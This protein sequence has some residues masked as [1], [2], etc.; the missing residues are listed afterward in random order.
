MQPDKRAVQ[1]DKFSYLVRLS[2]CPAVRLNR[3]L[4]CQQVRPNRLDQRS[5]ALICQPVPNTHD[6]GKISVFDVGCGQGVGN[7]LCTLTQPLES[8]DV[9]R[10]EL[11]I[12]EPMPFR[13]SRSLRHASFVGWVRSPVTNWTTS[14][15]RSPCVSARLD[16]RSYTVRISESPFSLLR[17]WTISCSDRPI[18]LTESSA[19]G[20]FP[21]SS[22]PV[23]A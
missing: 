8:W 4:S 19:P 12:Q 18:S 7:G 6:E 20:R 17:R 16:R 22:L 21:R 5:L 13:P 10:I 14:L 15:P 1:P 9:G 2:G 3:A 11:R 23:R